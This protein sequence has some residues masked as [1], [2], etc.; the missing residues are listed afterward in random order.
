MKELVSFFQ[1]FVDPDA[2]IGQDFAVVMLI[3]YAGA[4]LYMADFYQLAKQKSKAETLAVLGIPCV[5]T[6][7]GS[8]GGCA[9]ACRRLLLGGSSERRRLVFGRKGQKPVPLFSQGGN[10]KVFRGGRSVVRGGVSVRKTVDESFFAGQSTIIL[11]FWLLCDIIFAVRKI[12]AGIDTGGN[13]GQKGK[14]TDNEQ[15]G[16]AL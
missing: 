9:A 6:M 7:M 3:L 11:R 4:A 13:C 14:G 16:S 5:V 8:T 12:Y 10:G 15:I 1:L 2:A